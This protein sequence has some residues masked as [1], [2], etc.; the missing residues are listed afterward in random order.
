MGLSLLKFRIVMICTGLLV[1]TWQSGPGL[2]GQRASGMA[3]RDR[4]IGQICILISLAP[5]HCTARIAIPLYA[6]IIVQYVYDLQVTD[7]MR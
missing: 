6:E 5:Q 1:G 7:S 4:P 2:A 3:R